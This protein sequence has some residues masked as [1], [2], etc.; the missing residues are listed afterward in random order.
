M[1]ENN[2]NNY[3]IGLDCGTSSVGWAVTDDHYN[4]LR[5]KGKTL[6]GFRLFDEAKTA[7]DR[8]ASRSSRRRTRRTADR[9]KLLNILF[10][11]E[12]S[13]IDPEFYLRLKKSALL[14][15]DKNLKQN[16][17]NTLFD[18][19]NFKDKDF[20]KAYP[21]IWHLRKAI[22]EAPMDKHFDLRL[23]YLAIHHILTHRGHFLRN[24]EKIEGAGN[25]DELFTEFC[26]I[27]DSFGIKLDDACAD[28]F[29]K[30][31]SNQKLGKRDKARELMNSIFKES[32]EP[33]KRYAELTKLLSGSKTTP[34]A[35]FEPD[36]DKDGLKEAVSFAFSDS[37]IEDKLAE[38]ESTLDSDQFALIESAKKIYDYGYL[39]ELLNGETVLSNAMVKN[40]EI[41]E[42]E[43]AEL[44][45]LLRP[46]KEDYDLFFKTEKILSEKTVCYNAYIGKAYTEDKTGRRKTFRVDQEALNKEIKRLLEEHGL[47]DIKISECNSR[48]KSGKSL[49]ELLPDQK[50]STLAALAENSQLLPK[51]KGQAKGTIP[52]Q[53]HHSELEKIL[54]HLTHDYPSFAV[55]TNEKTDDAN[56]YNT[57]TK[58]IARIHDFRIPY[59]C[60]PIQNKEHSEWAWN[61]E[62][63]NELVRPWNF[64]TL[65]DLDARAN[66]FIQRMKNECTYLL[67]EDTLPKASPLYQK[68][69]VLNELNNLKINGNRIDQALKDFIYQNI[70]LDN[71]IPGNI[72]LKSLTEKLRGFGRISSTDELS[73]A[74]EQK[75]LPKLSTHNDLKN[76]FGPNYE[77]KFSR[78][79]IEEAI[80]LVTILNNE[81]KKLVEKLEECLGENCSTEQ[82]KKLARK[83]YKD[84]GK[85]SRAFLTEIKIEKD[86]RRISILEMLEETTD[87]LMELLG[88]KYHFKDEIDKFN[89]LKNPPKTE[90]DYED[91]K[92]LYCS[93]AVK[94]TI[95]QALKLIDELVKVEGHAPEK[96]FLEATREKDDPKK[97]GKETLSRHNQLKEQYKKITNS[98]TAKEIYNELESKEPR[99]LQQKK[100]YLYFTQMGHC[101]YCG[102]RIHLDELGTNAYDIDHIFPRSKT[103]DD[104][105]TKNLV[106]VH[107]H[108]NREKTNTYPISE[109]IRSKMAGT[110]ASW[111]QAGLITGEKYDRLKRNTPLNPEELSGFI[112]RQIVET[113]QSVKALRDLLKQ[114]YPDTKIV[115]VKAGQVSD[116]R[117][118]FANG[119]KDLETGEV[120]VPGRPEFIKLRNL[121]DLH[122]AKDAYLNIVVGNVMNMTFTDDPR[123]W[124][125]KDPNNL[126]EY[127]INSHNI[128]RSKP[129]PN[130]F[131]RGWYY[132]DSINI[133]S[134][135]MSHNN[136][137]WTRMPHLLTATNGGGF[138]KQTI[139]GK[140]RDGKTSS[141][142][143]PRKHNLDPAKYG[144]YTSVNGSHFA[145][146]EQISG[147]GNATR[148]I[149]QIPILAQQN[150]EKFIQEKYSNATIIVPVI[151]MNSLLQINGNLVHLMGRNGDGSLI[152]APASQLYL[153]DKDDCSYLKKIYNVNKK[154]METKNKKDEKEKYKIDAE[155]DGITS[156][157]NIT[158][159]NHLVERLS[160]FKNLKGLEHRVKQLNEASTS[161]ANLSPDEQCLTLEKIVTAFGCNTTVSDLSA[162][163]DKAGSV[164]KA[165]AG[166]DLSTLDSVFLIHQSPTGLFERKLDLKTCPPQTL[167]KKTEEI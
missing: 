27:C 19:P 121:N 145:L 139:L 141:D 154:L 28:T 52:Q 160:I 76:T 126:K 1:S 122:H 138:Y 90:I 100:L 71:I 25:F 55:E 32:D 161:F 4:L 165:S 127:S 80:N 9:V 163:L 106:L 159:Y 149:V 92:N 48:T 151:P 2:K 157:R 16:S 50:D 147:D 14:E 130:T 12:M 134:K 51:Q 132:Q 34:L 26:D 57:K 97:K 103:K 86:G 123:S 81:P 70:F 78:D 43:L 166:Q 77:K 39:K 104:G 10:E 107:A 114:K 93:P 88:S 155:K 119:Y 137:L 150:P 162:I 84:W 60:G 146:I 82:A 79:Q 42:A 99:D 7:A 68:Y 111:R 140:N 33:D 75:F 44:K 120:I 105:I 6:W 112:S 35:I 58:K 142:L 47:G 133:I 24:D 64:K 13:K 94:R 124:F 54:T 131:I 15:D 102:E 45:R 66:E 156:E 101:A 62:E 74:A 91:V 136:V 3:Y 21:T 18:D 128:W 96:I 20:H 17:K 110:W 118:Y 63:I 148:K 113:A 69:M 41:H 144:G 38:A 117:H 73:G 98:E 30:L 31:I 109:D 11:D 89:E 85:F 143:I 115:L 125:K 83:S 49:A 8:R 108:E 167:N 116:L 61:D 65:V 40:Y 59:Y 29:E 23:Y 158:F 95:W 164:G 87:N 46:F 22:I 36:L 67:G 56:K 129:K 5:A 153:S 135:N 152:L 72:T 37:N 53:L